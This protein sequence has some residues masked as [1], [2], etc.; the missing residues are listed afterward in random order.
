MQYPPIE[1]DCAQKLACTRP[2]PAP[3]Q[4]SRNP[5]CLAALGGRDVELALAVACHARRSRK[6]RIADEART[7]YRE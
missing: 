6:V 4:R 3:P 5:R 7:S 1:R 2:S